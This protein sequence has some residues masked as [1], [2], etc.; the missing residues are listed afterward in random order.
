MKKF[1]LIGTPLTHSFSQGYFKNKF[2]EE[3][4]LNSE[5]KNY[6]IDKVS[7]IRNLIKKEKNI[8]GLNV[9][10]PYKEQV[11]PYLDN[12]ESVAKEI[13]SVNVINKE[14]K[15]LIGYNTDYVAFMYSLKL[16]LPH[17]EFSSIVLGT[18][19]S[20]KAIKYA[21]KELNIPSLFVSR[22]PTSSEISYEELL[23]G[24]FIK[25]NKLIINTTPLGMFPNI[26]IHPS[27]NF[28]LL[29]KNHYVYDL[30]YNPEIT[31]FLKLSM[32][33]GSKIKNGY[34]M[35]VKQAELSWEIWNK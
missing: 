22:K 14:S 24:D 21:L 16:W 12:T 35:L 8:C 29:S 20:S 15:K 33:N 5:Y 9:T 34:E 27:F 3:N 13:G 31:L 23:K 7:Y 4:I 10:I 30:I 28:K 6:E 17:L 2:K 1:G 18:G 11:I 26:N 32:D 19:G 25:N